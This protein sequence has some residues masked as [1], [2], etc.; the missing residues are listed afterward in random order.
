MDNGGIGCLNCHGENRFIGNP[1]AT[2][3]TGCPWVGSTMGQAARDP[4]FKDAVNR[5]RE[6][7]ADWDELPSI[8]LP[9]QFDTVGEKTYLE[10]RKQAADIEFF[11]SGLWV[12][13]LFIPIPARLF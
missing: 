1:P 2:V 5:T 7:G 3:T 8:N 13:C 9:N 6:V 10:D 4:I 11:N 12:E